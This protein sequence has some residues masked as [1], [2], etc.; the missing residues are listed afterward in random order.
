MTLHVH[1][2]L[3]APRYLGAIPSYLSSTLIQSRGPGGT[4]DFTQ[5]QHATLHRSYCDMMLAECQGLRIE[6][7]NRNTQETIARLRSNQYWSR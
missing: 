1:P 7:A 6:A 5:N 4:F 2:S 3:L